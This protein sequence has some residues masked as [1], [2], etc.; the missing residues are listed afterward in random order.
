MTTTG[1]MLSEEE[2]LVREPEASYKSEFRDGRVWAMSGA[3]PEHSRIMGN[4]FT[5]I[6]QQLK[7]RP[8]RAYTSDTRVKVEAARFYTYPDLSVTCEKPVFDERDRMALLNPT[9]IVEVLSPST[10]DYDRGEKFAYYKKLTSLWEYV[11]VAQDTVRVEH[12]QRQ[13]D[14]G[15]TATTVEGLD[16]WVDLPRIGC[17]VALRDIYDKVWD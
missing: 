14:G 2:Y 5:E 9:L 17:R 10:A 7:G 3:S 12:F 8:C 4:M 6:N 1:D 13:E 16:A 11:L 15:W